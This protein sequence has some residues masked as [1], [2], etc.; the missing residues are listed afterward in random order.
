M[1]E[2]Y[3]VKIRIPYQENK[4]RYQEKATTRKILERLEIFERRPTRKKVNDSVHIIVGDKSETLCGEGLIL[5]AVQVD[6][7]HSF[8]DVCELCHSKFEDMSITPEPV[9]KCHRCR[10]KY[11]GS[12]AR[13][14]PY[15]Q[16]MVEL[17]KP[18]YKEVQ[19]SDKTDIVKRYEQAEAPFDIDLND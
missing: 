17:C 16:N 12:K 15:K 18:C 3:A 1:N 14:V 5:S 19:Q 9:I 11:G 2:I 8:D 4:A 6:G 7:F 13:L 10:S